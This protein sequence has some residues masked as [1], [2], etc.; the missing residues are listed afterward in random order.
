[1]YILLFRPT[2]A[3]HIRNKVYIVKNSYTFL[4]ICIN[5]RESLLIY[6]QVACRLEAPHIGRAPT[7]LFQILS[8]AYT[9][10]RI[11]TSMYCKYNYLT[12]CTTF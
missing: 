2:N 6:A 12:H 1:M 3:Q 11:T 9:A 5:F 7:R 10:T 8:I 4:C